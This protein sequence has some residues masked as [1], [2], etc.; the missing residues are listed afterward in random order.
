MAA[1]LAFS[2]AQGNVPLMVF[3]MCVTHGASQLSPTHVCLV[4]AADYFHLPLGSLVRRT[5]P[6]VALFCLGAAAYY[7][8]LL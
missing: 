2:A 1:P 7:Q 8:L 5:I 6:A 4:V 3:L